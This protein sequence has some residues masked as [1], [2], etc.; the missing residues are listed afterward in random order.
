MRTRRPTPR[1][2]TSRLVPRAC[3]SSMTAQHRLDALIIHT[4]AVLTE[5]VQRCSREAWSKLGTR[6]QKCYLSGG[7]ANPRNP[8]APGLTEFLPIKVVRVAT[9][10]ITFRNN[11]RGS[12]RDTSSWR[13]AHNPRSRSYPDGG[14]PNGEV[15]LR[16]DRTRHHRFAVF[17]TALWKNAKCCTFALFHTSNAYPQG[18]L[19][20]GCLRYSACV[21]V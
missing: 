2:A 14:F 5:E 7:I 9:I 10:A 6:T 20:M 12:V 16:E 3:R 15:S 21:S 11:R 18:C 1:I 13:W 19:K 8:A 4:S 17:E